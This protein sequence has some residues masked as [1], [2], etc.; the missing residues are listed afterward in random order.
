MKQMFLYCKM[1]HLLVNKNGYVFRW[2][3]I[4]I[5]SAFGN[6]IHKMLKDFQCLSKHCSCHLQEERWRRS[7]SNH[8]VTKTWWKTIGY[9]MVTKGDDEKASW[10][11]WLGKACWNSYYN[12]V[13]KKDDKKLF[14]THMSVCM[15]EVQWFYGG[16]WLDSLR[17]REDRLYLTCNH[18]HA[19][20]LGLFI[21]F[22]YFLI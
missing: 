12:Q 5:T 9:G 22:N 13:V 7:S 18:L 3:E 21:Y 20:S 4:C 15:G 16:G 10:L 6:I 14:C 2:L 8:A 19:S 1:F 17:K 11:T